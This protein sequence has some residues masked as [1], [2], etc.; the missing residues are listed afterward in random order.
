MDVPAV[1][2]QEGDVWEIVGFASAEEGRVRF[3][4]EERGSDSLC[5]CEVYFEVGGDVVAD[6]GLGACT[7]SKVVQDT[8]E[9]AHRD[10]LG[11]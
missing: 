6:E 8:E 9:D 5:S 1:V 10:V 7:L 3:R 11:R 4:R 2:E